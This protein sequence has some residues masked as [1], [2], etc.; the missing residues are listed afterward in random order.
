[1]SSTTV[2]RLTD[3]PGVKPD[4]VLAKALAFFDRNPDEILTREDICLKWDCC[5]RTAKSVARALIREGVPRAQLPRPAKRSRVKKPNTF[6]ESLTPAEVR[7]IY[8][9]HRYG[10]VD[11]A[12]AA[13]EVTSNTIA[14]QL[15]DARRKAGV[16]KTSVLV[17]MFLAS[18]AAEGDAP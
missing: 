6:P 2:H 9:F 3:A 11:A 18:E 7:A 1:M 5:P 8:A 10:S 14:S 4:T 13:M 16:H 17:D 15:R 12:A